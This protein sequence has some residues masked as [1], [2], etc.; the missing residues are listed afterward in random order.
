MFGGL[1]LVILLLII[2]TASGGSVRMPRMRPRG[3]VLVNVMQAP[4]QSVQ[5][6][7]PVLVDYVDGVPDA[8][9]GAQ[10]STTIPN[11]KYGLSADDSA[12]YSTVYSGGIRT[13]MKHTPDH[14]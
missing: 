12:W 6:H 4:L 11:L 1:C 5:T 13:N 14:L 9:W 10:P 8:R 3:N 2:F 7:L